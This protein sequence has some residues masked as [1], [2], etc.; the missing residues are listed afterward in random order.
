MSSPGGSDRAYLAL[1]LQLAERGL[2]TTD[3]NPRVGCVLVRDDRIIGTGWHRSAGDAH[4][5]VDAIRNATEDASGATAYVTLEPCS[6]QGRTGACCKALVAAGVRRVVAAMQDP[7]PAVAGKGFDYLRDAG[8]E[9]V[10]PLLEGQARALN[11]G[12]IKRLETGIPLVRCK[13]AMSLDGRTALAN[14]T[15]KWISS[16]DARRDVQKLRARSSAIVT[17]IGTVLADDPSQTI[18]AGE[19]DVAE[20]DLVLQHQPLR[21]IL[22]PDLQITPSARLFQQPGRTVVVCTDA[23]AKLAGFSGANIEL[24]TLAGNE[25]NL[26]DLEELLTLLA[27]RECNEVLFET[28]ATLAGS[29]IQSGKLD[30]LILYITG[31]LLGNDALPLARLAEL[32]SME[33]AVELEFTDIRHVGTDIRLT[34]KV[35][36]RG[37]SLLNSGRIK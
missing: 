5:E 27:D 6:H 35:K 23:N 17:G 28:G 34:A 25:H 21:V 33:D 11:P 18:R 14:G 16:A 37:D 24:I 32:T 12:Y 8:I 29:L 3:P 19:L 20:A 26:V 9:V 4:A 22:D 30:E 31:R 1:A 13:L 7:F 10:T 36:N 15:S 2:Y